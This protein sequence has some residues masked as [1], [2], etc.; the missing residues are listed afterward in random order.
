MPFK[1]GKIIYDQPKKDIVKA[2]ER[3]RKVADDMNKAADALVDGDADTTH[4]LVSDAYD[5]ID[6][7][8]MDYTF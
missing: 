7:L 1:P 5:T 2:I 3:I 6:D 4:K 8:L